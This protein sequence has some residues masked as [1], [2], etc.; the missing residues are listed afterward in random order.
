MNRN[1]SNWIQTNSNIFLSINIYF[2]DVET[3]KSVFW[4]ILEFLLTE[5]HIIFSENCPQSLVGI[6][7]STS[8]SI[9]CCSTNLVT[10]LIVVALPNWTNWTKRLNFEGQ[11]NCKRDQYYLLLQI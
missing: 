4:V 5:K 2:L 9:F 3:I 6:E 11:V 10:E 7:S 1:N 8:N